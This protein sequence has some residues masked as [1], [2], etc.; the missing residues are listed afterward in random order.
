MSKQ[1]WPGRLRE[2]AQDWTGPGGL[3]EGALS[4]TH[5]STEMELASREA[6]GMNKN[7]LKG[8]TL[9]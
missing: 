4:H 9:L 2:V 3:G 5:F 1:K 8:Q 7:E 6:G